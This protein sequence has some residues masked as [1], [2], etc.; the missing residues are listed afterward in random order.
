SEERSTDVIVLVAAYLIVCAGVSVRGDDGVPCVDMVEAAVRND[1]V[2][3]RLLAPK[4]DQ[5]LVR[6]REV[7]KE[8]PPDQG[9]RGVEQDRAAVIVS[10]I[11]AL[12]GDVG[13]QPLS[14][15]LHDRAVAPEECAA[16]DGVVG[17]AAYA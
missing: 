6:L 8:V 15:Q 10:E 1:I 2:A 11:A 16:P 5:S 14:G 12:H 13:R 3:V 17:V 9:L 4:I 7:F